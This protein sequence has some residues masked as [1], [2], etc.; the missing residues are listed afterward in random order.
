MQWCRCVTV[1]TACS[2]DAQQFRCHTTDLCIPTYYRCDGENLCGD[3]SDELYCSQHILIVLSTHMHMVQLMP[4]PLHPKPDVS[5]SFK[6]RLASPSWYLVTQVVVEKRPLNG[7]SSGSGRG[8]SRG[9]S[10]CSISSS[11][12]SLYPVVLVQSSAVVYSAF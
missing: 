4:L 2:D 8:G 7:C 1:Y 6:F 9:S 12:S 5:A 3:W 11:S 10:S